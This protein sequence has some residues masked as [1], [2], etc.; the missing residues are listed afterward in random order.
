LHAKRIILFKGAL[1]NLR[2][3]LGLGKRKKQFLQMFPYKKKKRQQG[4]LQ[5]VQYLLLALWKCA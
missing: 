3:W 2:F 4:K 1:L 5:N